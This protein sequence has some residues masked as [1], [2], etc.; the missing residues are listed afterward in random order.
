LNNLI[1][2]PENAT[3][4]ELLFTF[5]FLKSTDQIITMNWPAC[6]KQKTDK[7]YILCVLYFQR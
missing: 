3:F 2:I 4:K 5:W 7:G 1:L 6:D